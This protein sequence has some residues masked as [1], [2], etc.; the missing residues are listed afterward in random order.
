MISIDSP[1]MISVVGH[2]LNSEDAISNSPVKFMVGGVAMFIRL[3]SNHQIVSI[4]RILWNPRVR[5]I[6]RVLVRS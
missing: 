6:I 1:N 5:A 3:T 2:Q 4:G